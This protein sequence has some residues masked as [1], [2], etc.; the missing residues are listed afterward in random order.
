MMT[1]GMAMIEHSDNDIAD[2]GQ[3]RDH[4]AMVE[5]HDG[6]MRVAL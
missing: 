5:W 1:K 4:D 6:D 2:N 3:P